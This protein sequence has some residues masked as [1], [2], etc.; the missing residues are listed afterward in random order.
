MVAFFY[1]VFGPL[2][3]QGHKKSQ[4]GIR[5][6]KLLWQQAMESRIPWCLFW[7]GGRSFGWNP[8]KEWS[9]CWWPFDA[10]WWSEHRKKEKYSLSGLPKGV[11]LGLVGILISWRAIY[12][13]PS[14]WVFECGKY[15]TCLIRSIWKRKYGQWPKKLPLNCFSV[16]IGSI[17]MQQRQHKLRSVND[18]AS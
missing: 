13:I 8:D 15:S 9:H 2:L 11:F 10:W 18:Q 16:K 6:H 14:E 5:I 1:F 3:L 17:F 4:V 12:E 7:P